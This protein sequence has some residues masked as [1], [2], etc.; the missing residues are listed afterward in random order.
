MQVNHYSRA[1]STALCVA[2]KNCD[3]ALIQV[4]WTYM[5][6]IKGLKEV[7][8]ELIHSRS[9]Q[10]TR[11][12]ILVTKRLSDTAVDALLFQGSHGSKNQ[13]IV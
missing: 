13:N 7:G 10:N 9:I 1:A 11:T 4:P 5:A 2:T 3:A 6:E 8:G 12:C